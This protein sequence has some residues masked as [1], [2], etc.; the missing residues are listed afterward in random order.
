MNPILI[1]ALVLFLIIDPLAIFAFYLL[2][3]K[4]ITFVIVMVL[5]IP[6]SLISLLS[7][8]VGLS[9]LQSLYWAA[10]IGVAS[11][12]IGYYIIFKQVGHPIRDLSKY[13]FEVSEGNLKVTIDEHYFKQNN[14]IGMISKSMNNMLVR[15][16]KIVSDVKKTAHV[17]ANISNELHNSSQSV[18]SI[19]SEQA[20]SFEEVS[21]SVSQIVDQARNNTIK[22]NNAEKVVKDS[23]QS[24]TDNNIGVQEVLK[25]LSEII[26]KIENINSIAAQTNILS[27][28]A[29]IE[30]ARAGN[31]GKGFGVV[32]GEVGKLAEKSKNFASEISEIS[33]K[34]AEKAKLTGEL[35]QNIVPQIKDTAQLISEIADSGR[36]QETNT[37]HIQTALNQLNNSVQNL[38]SISEESA[39]TSEELSGQAETLKS[40]ISYFQTS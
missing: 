30:A 23:V 27:L 3:K 9:G 12:M 14:E 28:N 34:S 35:S 16:N 21:A 39:A 20:A 5:S 4:T 31:A 32:A 24:I 8:I 25:S 6:I 36:E 29:A 22:A 13:I 1:Y 17:L 38:A 33:S 10:P 2:F 11:L 15:L 40:L 26:E 7:Y 37:I 18:V 19:S